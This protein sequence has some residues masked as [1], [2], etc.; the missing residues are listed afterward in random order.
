MIYAR[1]V[2][3]MGILGKR[4]K[5]DIIIIG[6]GLTGVCAAVAAR[7][8]GARV[9]LLEKNQF[10]GGMATGA[11]IHS[12]LT[13]HGKKGHKI[14]GGIPQEIIDKLVAVGG[15]PGHIR[16]TIGVAYSV[17]PTDPEKLK[18]ILQTLLDKEGVRYF[19]DTRFTDAEMDGNRINSIRGINCAGTFEAEAP[20]YIDASGEGILA[21]TAGDSFESGRDGKTQPATLIFKVRNVDIKKAV[22]YALNNRGDFHH[23]T[24]FSLLETSPAPGLSGF[25]TL[26]NRANLS[27]P[28]DRLLFYQTLYG[29][30]VGINSTRI[31]DFDPLDP[32]NVTFSQKKARIQMFEILNFLKDWI[33]GFEKCVLTGEAPLMG[34]REV[35]RI[36]GK[37]FLKGEDLLVGRRF[38]DEVAL[39]GFPID[40]HTP[41]SSTIES[42][43]IGA[44]GYYGIPYR[45]LLPERTPNLLIAGKCV[46][47]DFFAHAS[48]RVQATSMAMGQ[49]AGAAAA[50]AV[51]KGVEPVDLNTEDV[52]KAVVKLGGILSPDTIDDL[53]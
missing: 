48:A 15:S 4:I 21:A 28:R 53:L 9:L 42:D 33:P 19:L 17:T 18:L 8:T 12:C 30:E 51:L 38:P 14:V 45:C 35:R 39:G 23:E 50:I 16:D 24:I 49:A 31:P 2:K 29:D 34:I 6:G 46:S 13:F 40:I 22:E 44:D 27:V 41:G 32:Y 47:A 5:T 1:D 20:A 25:F 43:E 26:W 52:K 7:R 37:Y 36:K 11:W 10:L 3:K